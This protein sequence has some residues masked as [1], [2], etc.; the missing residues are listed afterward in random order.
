MPEVDCFRGRLTVI[1]PPSYVRAV[2]V[3]GP[4]AVF[5]LR[6]LRPRSH[7]LLR[8]VQ[9]KTVLPRVQ[10]RCRLPAAHRTGQNSRATCQRLSVPRP[11]FRVAE[12]AHLPGLCFH[13]L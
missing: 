13:V 11:S 3:H 4:P 2:H 6:N 9:P 7:W 5:L 10:A 8:V 12:E 1:P